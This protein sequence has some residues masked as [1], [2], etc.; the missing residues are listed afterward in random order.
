MFKYIAFENFFKLRLLDSYAEECYYEKKLCIR[1]HKNLFLI[2]CLNLVLCKYESEQPHD[3]L[4]H[5]MKNVK[6]LRNYY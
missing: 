5:F 1:H 2:K 4:R 6:C 3:L